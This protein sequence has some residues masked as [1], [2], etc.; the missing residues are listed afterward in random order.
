MPGIQQNGTNLLVLKQVLCDHPAGTCFANTWGVPTGDVFT[1]AFEGGSGVVGGSNISK[2]GVG[3]TLHINAPG[4]VWALALDFEGT[5]HHIRNDGGS[6]YALGTKLGEIQ[7]L[8]SVYSVRAF[9]CMRVRVC[10]RAR[11]RVCVCACVR[12]CRLSVYVHSR[13]CVCVCV[14]WCLPVAAR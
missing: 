12:M 7:G 11:V 2:F 1:E 4:R 9:V 6:L 8:P 13:E 14:R 10:V 5:Q 3:P